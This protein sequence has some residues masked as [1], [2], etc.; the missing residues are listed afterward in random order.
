MITPIDTVDSAV[1]IG[2]GALITGVASY[3]LAK[4]NHDKTAEKERAQRKRDMLEVTAQQVANF[5]QVMLKH[6]STVISWLAFTAPAEPMSEATHAEL[7]ELEGECF[8]VFTEMVSAQAKLQLLGEIECYRLLK[9]YV[10]GVTIYRQGPIAAREF[11][12]DDL[13][14]YKDQLQQDREVFFRT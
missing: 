2:L 8:G 9:K 11:N 14:T 13:K 6:W 7:T 10:K 3:W 1:K 12:V 5:D 4:A